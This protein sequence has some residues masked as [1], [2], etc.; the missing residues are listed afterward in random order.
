MCEF[1]EV[2]RDIKVL[3]CVFMDVVDV[4]GCENGNVCK[5]CGDYG[6][7]DGCGVIVVSGYIDWYIC[8]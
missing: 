1:Y 6:C 2:G 3:I 5:M 4:F 7:G 8:M